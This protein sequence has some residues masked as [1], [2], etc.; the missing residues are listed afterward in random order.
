M[1]DTTTDTTTD[2]PTDAP[3]DTGRGTA[4]PSHTVDSAPEAARQT[5][6][7][8]E[9]KFG[10]L[11][12]AVARMATSPETLHGFLR[13][14]AL[15]ESGTLPPLARETLVL[16]M[17]TRN[18][19]HVCVAMHTAT[20]VRLGASD[21]LIRALR[22]GRPLA[23]SDLE[24]VRLFTLA[25]LETAGAVGDRELR[26][27]LEAGFTTRQALEVV[28]GIGTYTISTLANRLTEAPVDEAF[29]AHRWEAA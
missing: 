5:V 27:Y 15:F 10:F 13:A 25:V 20:L 19:C 6:A 24:A 14:S 23:Q 9:G 28:L 12:G 1:T 21:D 26:D 17:A 22:E 16:T 18:R 29:N 4:F 2:A 11:P 8:V 7:G 3:T